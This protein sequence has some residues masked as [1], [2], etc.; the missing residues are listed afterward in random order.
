VFRYFEHLVDPYTPYDEV[1]T[2]PRRLLPFLLAY[3]GPFKRVFWWTLASSVVIAGIEVWF[4]AYMGG[5]I[6]TLTATSP[7]AFW[8]ERGTEMILMVLFLMI[9]FPAINFV[10]YAL[11]NNTI[12]P[13]LGT[14]IRWRAHRHVLRQSVGWFENDFAGRIANRI[15]QVPPAAG[16]TAFQVFD[17]VSYAAAYLVGCL[18]LLWAADVRLTLPLLLWA[19]LFA[20]LVYWTISRMGP[21]AK[22]AS[23]LFRSPQCGVRC[24]LVPNRCKRSTLFGIGLVL[25]PRFAVA[26]WRR[27]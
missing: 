5:L 7:D 16:E 3:T 22:R 2:P 18:I 12:L 19:G 6:D 21:A 15:V 25:S 17:A 11:L 23:D 1:D 8:A 4:I 14:L 26:F 24:I 20:W 13:N 9:I 27:R 10:G